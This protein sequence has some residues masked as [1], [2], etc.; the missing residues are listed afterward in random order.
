M[1]QCGTALT[2][3]GDL[4]ALIRHAR[5]SRHLSQ[6]ELAEQLGVSRMTISRLERGGDVASSTA[7]GAMGL[8][9]LQLIPQRRRDW[10]TLLELAN[11]IKTEL[12]RGDEGFAI[13]RLRIALKDFED[14]QAPDDIEDFLAEPES[15]GDQRWDTL[16]ATATARAARNRGLK[17][18]KWTERPA[19]RESW[20]PLDQSSLMIEL[21][22]K[23]TAPE[24]ASKNIFIDEREWTL[25]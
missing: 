18:P 6:D 21:I 8:C 25:A 20:I 1:N 4:G 13:R 17:A 14:L 10:S 16:L 15:T 22:R 9:G 19:L 2:T 5:K 7:L 3:P 11:G 23:R 12:D 24:F